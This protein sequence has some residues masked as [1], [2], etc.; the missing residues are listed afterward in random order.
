MTRLFY[1]GLLQK[2]PSQ[3]L[4]WEAFFENKFLQPAMSDSSILDN[5]DTWLQV[6]LISLHELTLSLTKSFSL[7][8]LQPVFSFENHGEEKPVYVTTK[9]LVSDIKRALHGAIRVLADDQLLLDADGLELEDHLTMEYYKFN[10][11]KKPMYLISKQW[12][13]PGADGGLADPSPSSYPISASV[14]PP[15]GLPKTFSQILHAVSSSNPNGSAEARLNEYEGVFKNYHDR[16]SA[17]Y[18]LSKTLLLEIFQCTK[19][20]ETQMKVYLVLRTY[21]VLRGGKL[22]ETFDPVRE[23]YAG[24]ERRIQKVVDMFE[25]TLKVMKATQVDSSVATACGLTDRPDR[26]KV[27]LDCL[28]ERAQRE[29]FAALVN[30]FNQLKKDF[31]DVKETTEKSPKL[32][33]NAIGRILDP[34]PHKEMLK[35]LEEAKNVVTT[36]KQLSQVRTCRV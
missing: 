36:M 19:A 30:G 2:K 7:C 13:R 14:E 5:Q 35:K 8:V 27:L 23:L 18:Q 32:V 26:T 4:D 17:L 6:R 12:L 25:N 16:V 22:G 1:A 9:T 29:S 11:K 3:R 33:E 31:T 21:T 15:A 34:T 24:Q 20:H 28:D 10:T